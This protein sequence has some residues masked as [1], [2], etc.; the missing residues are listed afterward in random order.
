MVT[1]LHTHSTFCDGENTPEEIVSYAIEHGFSSIGFSG[2][3]YTGFDL[4]YCMK[5]AE[6]Y[7]AEINRLKKV[8]KGKIQ[9]YLG[10]EEEMFS[11]VDRSCFDYTIGSSHYFYKNGTYY[12]IDSSYEY[13][14]KCLE[15]FDYDVVNLAETYYQNF[16][17]YIQKRRP[18]IIG[19]FDLITKFDEV[20]GQRFSDNESYL[21]IAEKYTKEALKSDCIFEVNTGAISKGY[22]SLPYPS[23]NLLYVIRK[24]GG[25]V[26]ISSDSHKVETLDFKFNEMK[27]MLLDIG[28]QYIYVLYDGEFKK[29]LLRG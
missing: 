7:I 19:H 13:F 20:D 17:G 15:I 11:I 18:D 4:R 24:S 2:H 21:R 3:G 26:T 9:I 14:K 27:E 25:K 22:K 5:N 23:E 29:E 16:V 6:G 8:Y 12:P 1:N 10:A 28:F